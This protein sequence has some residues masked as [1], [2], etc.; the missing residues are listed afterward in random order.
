M[1]IA[2]GRK[3]HLPHQRVG[4]SSVHE[5]SRRFHDQR[6]RPRIEALAGD[7]DVDEQTRHSVIQAELR[8]NN[9]SS[10]SHSPTVPLM[11]SIS[12]RRGIDLN[13]P[14]FNQVAGAHQPI[15]LP[16]S[17]NTDSRTINLSNLLTHSHSKEDLISIHDTRQQLLRSHS[18]GPL[19]PPHDIEARPWSRNLVVSSPTEAEHESADCAPQKEVFRGTGAGL[20]LLRS[21][22]S[23]L[24]SKLSGPSQGLSHL[25]WL[26]QALRAISKCDCERVRSDVLI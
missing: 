7:E 13:I 4:V 15:F 21:H 23:Q 20:S 22:G 11:S 16:P 8:H 2:H 9:D 14:R 3:D 24:P 25:P 10:I 18:L 6:Y 17:S 19:T 5:Q 1:D 26:D 12:N